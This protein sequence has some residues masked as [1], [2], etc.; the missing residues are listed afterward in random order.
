MITPEL[1]QEICDSG[2]KSAEIIEN[3]VDPLI[4]TP[5]ELA[6]G[7]ARPDRHVAQALGGVRLPGNA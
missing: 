7:K 1:A 6:I 2:L 3:I 4:L 5:A